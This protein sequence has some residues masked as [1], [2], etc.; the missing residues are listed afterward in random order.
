[1]RIDL[2]TKHGFGFGDY[3]CMIS[4]WLDIPEPVTV[5]CDNREFQYDRLS[6]LHRLL[7]IPKEKLKIVY[8]EN[9]QGDFSGAWHVKIFSEYY[10]P[11]YINFPGQ[12]IVVDDPRRKK[13]AIG[14]SMYNGLDVYLDKDYNLIRG[15]SINEGP[16]G[17]RVPQAKWRTI[18][19][20]SR[21]FEACRKFGYD[22]ITLDHPGDIEF[23]LRALV[24]QCEAVIAY[25]GGIAHLCHMLNVPC[26]MLNFRDPCADC[27]YGPFQ[28][29]YMHQ[30]RS[31]YLLRNDEELFNMDRNQF[32][33]LIGSLKNGSG[34]NNRLIN[35]TSRFQFIKGANSKIDFFDIKD[36]RHVFRSL[37]GPQ[38]SESAKLFI[39]KYY[40]HK[41]PYLDT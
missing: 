34:T 14:I 21:V 7:D 20:Y 8:K 5:Y 27:V 11:R 1:M 40:K 22:V 41:F 36:N 6:E 25:E 24:E 31:M 12:R 39:E 37:M 17:T 33:N 19:F 3:L 9:H 35:G 4:T 32:S 10:K 26:L 2:N 18:D 28:A 38:I 16:N 23:K 29:E 15:S 30:S 13:N